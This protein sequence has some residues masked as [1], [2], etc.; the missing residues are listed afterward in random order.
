M[1]SHLKKTAV[2]RLGVEDEVISAADFGQ[3]AAEVRKEMKTTA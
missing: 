1:H 3:A 2:Q